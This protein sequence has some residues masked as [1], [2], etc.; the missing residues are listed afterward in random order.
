MV[1]LTRKFKLQVGSSRR[2]AFISVNGFQ[3]LNNPNSSTI[4]NYSVW[5][6]LR[7]L[8]YSRTLNAKLVSVGMHECKLESFTW[9]GENF[10][11]GFCSRR[12]PDV[13]ELE[14]ACGVVWHPMQEL[15]RTLLPDHDIGMKQWTNS[16][17]KHWKR[18]MTN[19]RGEKSE[20]MGLMNQMKQ[21]KVLNEICISPLYLKG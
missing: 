10:L 14:R 15:H 17:C 16:I 5:C 1:A 11:W 2:K 3:W 21:S 4:L 13:G 9:Q 12:V 18:I 6:Q 19:K 20:K 7:Q 8:K